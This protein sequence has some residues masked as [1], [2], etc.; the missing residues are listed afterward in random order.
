MK[1]LSVLFISFVM[2][3]TLSAC[4]TAPASSE[5]AYKAGTYTG[6]AQGMNGE[7]VVEVEVSDDAILSVK[8][9]DEKE[10]DGISDPAI[11]TLPAEIVEYQSL[12][13]D[14]ITGCTVTS[15]AILEAAAKALES[16]GADLASLQKPVEKI[17]GETIEKTADVI[18]VGGGGAGISAAATVAS[19]GKTV[20]LIEKTAALG[21]NTLASGGVW[22]AVNA[23]LDALTPSDEGRLSTLRTYLEYDENLFVGELKNTYST[24]KQQINDYLS[25]DTS[26]LF[27]SVEFH[28]IQ[29]YLGGLREDL[30]G[31]TIYGSYDLL[32]TLVT[33]SDATISWLKETAGS[34][35]NNTLSEPIGS[36]WLRSQTPKTSKQVDF[37]DKPAAYVEKNGGEIIYQTT[38]DELYVENGRIVGVHAV[39]NDGTEVILHANNGVILATGG[40]AGNTEMVMKYDNYWG[41][42][43]Y[44]SIG[45]TNVSSTVGEGIIMAQKAADADVTGMEFTQLMPIGFASNG[46][47]A[48]GNGTNV[49]YVTPEGKRFVDEYAERDVISK[50]AFAN[51]GEQ[52]L[53]Y[54]IGLKSNVALWQ[55]EDCYEA[56]SIEELAKL[57]NMDPAVL[58][59]E[60]EK[61]NGYADAGLD[62]DF[63]KTVFTT[64]IETSGDDVYVAR[65]MKPSLHHTMGGLV[66]D[67]L[68]HVYNQSGEVIPGLYAA[69]EVTGGIHAG[70]RLG[71]NAIA[72]IYTFGHIAGQSAANAN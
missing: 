37:F 59:A 61:Y 5:T 42:D 45:S 58:T 13:L 34:E 7:V 8:I 3:V 21:G 62:A 51:S 15:T 40:F 35:F 69:G 72:D 2:A 71:G 18:V 56:S 32:N 23:E 27:D 41:D 14:T 9:T 60:V 66:I 49:M 28:L 33:N 6:S 57:I 63:G 12:G 24:L 70:N 47:L 29:S 1:K 11:E 53:F 26:T 65:A 67:T 17:A 36:L 64:K 50:A 38:A 22:N 31:N 10:T 16:A 55:D 39:K 4:S 19:E 52:G 43:L 20:I 48:L 46:R 30:D 68:C 44:A 25:G 54:E